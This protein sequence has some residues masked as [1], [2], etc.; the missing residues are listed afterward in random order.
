MQHH[1]KQNVIRPGTEILTHCSHV[2]AAIPLRGLREDG[3]VQDVT[4]LAL[5]GLESAPLESGAVV[6]HPHSKRFYMLNGSAA[7]LWTEL[8]TP[9]T[10]EQLVRHLRSAFPSVDESIAKQD[11]NT[12]LEQLKTLEL[13]SVH[14]WD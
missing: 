10:Q 3:T 2:R 13:V 7:L 12:A 4:Y 8:S 1:T 5:A 11:V 9:R 14:E 6:Y